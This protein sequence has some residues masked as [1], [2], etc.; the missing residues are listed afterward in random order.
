MSEILLSETNTP[1]FKEDV[2]ADRRTSR[3]LWFSVLVGK[4]NINRITGTNK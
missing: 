1:K 2:F 4:F 3:F